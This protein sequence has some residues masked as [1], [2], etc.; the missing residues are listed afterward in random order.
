VRV[1]GGKALAFL[2]GVTPLPPQ[3]ILG[4]KYLSSMVYGKVVSAKYS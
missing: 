2:G 4:V 1:M 3:G